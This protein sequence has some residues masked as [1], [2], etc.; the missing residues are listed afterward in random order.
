MEAIFGELLGVGHLRFTKKDK[1]GKP[2][3]NS[4]ALYAMT[5]KHYNHAFYLWSK[6]FSSIC[7]TT[8]PRP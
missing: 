7:T 5:L 6:I 4:N 3:L 8:P 1:N 2:K